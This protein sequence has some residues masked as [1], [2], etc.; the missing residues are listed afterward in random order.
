[1][2]TKALGLIEVIG[3]VP[4]IEAAD[5]ALK[6]ANVKLLGVDKV[7][8]GIMTVKITGDV[9]AVNAAVAAASS[10][11]A[12]IGTLRA[13][14]VIPRVQEDVWRMVIPSTYK[15]KQKDLGL[16][17]EETVSN[18]DIREVAEAILAFE[19]TEEQ[20]TEE[21]QIDLTKLPSMS[22]KE[23]KGLINRLGIQIGN[24]K[25]KNAKKQQLIDII[26]KFYKEGVD[27][28]INR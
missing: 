4:A 12:K 21:Q 3:Y 20:Q 16:P 25:L 22:L 9:G 5:S 24:S 1:M 23:L 14:H 10:S 28:G 8:G 27:G 19:E 11:A 6:A 13:S 18:E 26:T 2:T 15:E 17:I 7:D